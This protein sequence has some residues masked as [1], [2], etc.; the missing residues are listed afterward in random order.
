MSPRVK[1]GALI[2]GSLLVAVALVVIAGSLLTGYGLRLRSFLLDLPNL[3]QAVLRRSSVAT[4][5]PGEFRNIVFLHR[6]V[7]NNLVE[8]GAVRQLFTAA[9]YQFWD[10]DDNY[11]GLRDPAGNHLGYTYS[12]PAG[13]TE[14]DGLLK[15]FSQPIYNL[16][17]NTFSSLLQHEVIVFKSC[18]TANDIKSDAQLAE[19]KA[20]YLK[21]RDAID[22]HPD[23]IFIAV[24]PPPRN[25]AETTREE[26]R[27]AGLIADWLKSAEFLEGHP[28]LYTFDLFG[29]LV[30]DDP[31]AP[32]FNMLRASYR[33]GTDS[34]PNQFANETIG[35]QFVE[36]VTAAI[37]Q[38]KQAQQ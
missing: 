19:R 35:P 32:D 21:M 4:T 3:T 30:E 5:A 24:T 8:Q 38:H 33:N 18:F 23:R 36:F 28:N 26:A 10:V 2:A 15:I 31:A 9:G 37:E 1:R 7:G 20:W 14:P 17:V 12:V 16:P 34:H 25:P 27:R 13:N 6:S 22:R 11:R 29:A